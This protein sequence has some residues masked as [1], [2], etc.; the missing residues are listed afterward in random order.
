M[1]DFFR[2]CVQVYA[3][4]TGSNPDNYPRVPTP[5][6]PEIGVEDGLSG[7]KG[8]VD[9]APAMEA[10]R[11]CLE[12]C[13]SDAAPAHPDVP[14]SAQGGVLQPIAAKVRMKSLYGARMAPPDTCYV[15][16]ATPPVALPS[17]ISRTI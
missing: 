13:D 9:I 1:R 5:F 4:L 11:E 17:G 15:Q 3:D 12:A 6:G 7:P 10:L 14:A 8:S 16:Y 2:S